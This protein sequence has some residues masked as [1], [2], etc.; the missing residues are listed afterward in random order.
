VCARTVLSVAM[1]SVAVLCE[2]RA[3]SAE[4]VA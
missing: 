4:Q 1:L 2:R 3:A